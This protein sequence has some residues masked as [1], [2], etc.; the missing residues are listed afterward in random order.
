MSG[1]GN[2]YRAEVLHVHGIHPEVPANE[3]THWQRDA[4]WSTR[5]RWLRQA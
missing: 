2:V 4:M 3:V 1:V 5:L